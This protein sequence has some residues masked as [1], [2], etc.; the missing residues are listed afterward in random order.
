MARS[1]VR[2]RVLQVVV[3][4]T[5]AVVGFGATYVVAGA[6][7]AGTLRLTD[8]PT[9]SAPVAVDPEVA[10]VLRLVDEHD[11]WSGPAPADMKDQIPGHAV[12]T[13]PGRHAQYLSSDVG[14]A[15]WTG[16]REGRLH[17]FCR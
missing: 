15:I 4:P 16:E 7:V 14:F 13:L 9:D 11:C 17:A 6:L 2:R 5:A 8:D 12:V 3:W 1:E 10:R